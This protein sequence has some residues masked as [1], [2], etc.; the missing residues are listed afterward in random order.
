MTLLCNASKALAVQC[1][2]DGVL[3]GLLRVTRWLVDAQPHADWVRQGCRGGLFRGGLVDTVEAF[4]RA[5][6]QARVYPLPAA[7]QLF[8]SSCCRRAS[9][10][11]VHPCA[12]VAKIKE[13]MGTEV[14][15]C[16]CL[17]RPCSL[18]HSGIQHALEV[19]IC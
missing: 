3:G 15:A 10:D 12:Q 18:L 11:E 16:T 17:A 7:P 5:V 1:F 19:C 8:H 14:S 9:V 4:S 2:C 13:M 6:P